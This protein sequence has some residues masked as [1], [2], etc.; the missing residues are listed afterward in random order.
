MKIL[1]LSVDRSIRVATHFTQFQK[2]LRKVADVDFVFRDVPH[3]YKTGNYCTSVLKGDIKPQK[4]LENH[5][6][7]KNYDFIVTDAD[8]VYVHENWKNIKIPKAMIIE[9][10]Q[11]GVNP[12]LQMTWALDNEFDIIFY[13]YKKS[14]LKNYRH[15]AERIR[16]AWL[17]HSIDTEM[18]K[19]YKLKKQ[20][21]VLMVGQCSEKVYPNRTKAHKL[22]KNRPYFRKIDRPVESNVGDRIYDKWPVGEDYAKLLNQ[23]E[24]CI[25]G[26]SIFDFPVMKYFEI[27]ASK[28]LLV[29]NWFQ[30]LAD[31]GFKDGE[32]MV[33]ADYNKLH[34]QMKSL[35]SDKKQLRRLQ[36]SGYEF[37]RK[38]HKCENRA[39]HMIRILEEM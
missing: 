17:P 4:I 14:F 12:T 35:L 7:Q 36:N 3:G 39:D 11:F 1:F 28:S 18:F 19:D 29:S 37:I 26:G 32:N 30:E 34:S 31:L 21:D 5:L 25:T 6:K 9:D 16:C 33:V 13:K 38:F 15:V 8:F 27:P 22:L 24:I 2:A 23:S 10:S 20:Y